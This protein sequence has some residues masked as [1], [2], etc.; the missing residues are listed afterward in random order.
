MGLLSSI[1]GVFSGRT[2]EKAAIARRRFDGAAV[3]RFTAGWLATMDAIDTELRSDLDRLRT[4]AR[5]LAKNNP[6]VKRYLKMVGDNVVGPNGFKLQARV[7]NSP[8]VQDQLANDAIES[9]WTD[10]C[11]AADVTGQLSLTDLIT[12][13]ARA[14]ARD[15]EILLRHV[16]GVGKYGYAVQWIDI[17]RLDTQF[18]RPAANGL[19]AIHMGVEIDSYGRPLYFHILTAHPS[20]AA[21]AR[22][23]ERVP[24][25]DIIHAFVR[26]FPEQRRGIPWMHAVIKDLHNLN[27][28]DKSALTAARK[29]ADTLGFFVSPDGEPPPM[30][31][32]ESGEPIAVSVPGSYDTLPEGY[33]FR[34][35]ESQYPSATYGDFVKAHLRRIATGLGVSYNTLAEDLEG[36]NYSSIRSGTL[37][38]RDGWMATQNWFIGAVLEPIYREWLQLALLKGAIV[39]PNGSPLPLAKLAKFS[40]HTFQGRRWQWVDPLKDIEASRLAIQTGITSP[41]VVAAQNGMD[42]EEVIADIARFEQSVAGSGIQTISIGTAAQPKP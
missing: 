6:V 14:A 2:V 28:Y 37:N 42:V 12:G 31:A 19:N 23:H 29:G 11:R 4:R 1:K 25:S 8:G 33:D 36:V 7:E 30:D 15:G 10:F 18:N 9:A 38:E 5:D 35:Y 22:Q 32:E 34:P 3:D 16:R 24:A 20:L 17:D 13:A 21:T 27:E 26:D 41:Q 39:M 40:A